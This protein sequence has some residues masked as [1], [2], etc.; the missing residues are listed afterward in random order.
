MDIKSFHTEWDDLSV[1]RKRRFLTK[2]FST[3]IDNPV[4]HEPLL[5]DLLDWFIEA[6]DNDYFGTEGFD[7]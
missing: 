1:E 6:E 5:L 3:L 7:G 4:E 2:L